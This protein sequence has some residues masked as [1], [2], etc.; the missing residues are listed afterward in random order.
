MVLEAW[1]GSPPH[2]QQ[3]DLRPPATNNVKIRLKVRLSG[4]SYSAQPISFLIVEE[5]L[6]MDYRSE[7]QGIIC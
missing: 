1:G 6:T 5:E 7:A 3:N 4:P 2:R